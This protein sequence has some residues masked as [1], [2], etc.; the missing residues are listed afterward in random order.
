[1][2]EVS[3]RVVVINY[4]SSAF[5]PMTERRSHVYE[6]L[7][8]QANTKLSVI[9]SLDRWKQANLPHSLE[10]LEFSARAHDGNIILLRVAPPGRSGRFGTSCLTKLQQI[11]AL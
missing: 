1:M 5:C 9:N 4:D 6:P 7:E 10:E 2:I 8:V 11:T 3:A